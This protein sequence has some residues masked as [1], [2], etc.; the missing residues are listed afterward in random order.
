MAVQSVAQ[1]ETC[2]GPSPTEEESM[3]KAVPAAVLSVVLAS[4]IWGCSL[5]DSS[6]SSSDIVSSPLKSSSGSS[7]PSDEYRHDVRDF[8][9]AFLKSGGDA[10]TLKQEI[11]TVAEKHGVTDWESNKST[12]TGLGEG[13]AKAGVS[14]IELEAYQRTLADTDEQAG[15]M[16]E[17]YD[18]YES[19]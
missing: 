3:G 4:S 17:G 14:K 19:K 2:Y 13:L 7:S 16:K 11:G 1:G 10:S 15:W 12:Y 9:A 5:A 8:T 18:S 6:K